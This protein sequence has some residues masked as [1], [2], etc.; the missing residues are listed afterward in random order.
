MPQG[1]KSSANKWAREIATI[2]NHTAQLHKILVYQDD[3]VNTTKAFHQH[4]TTQ[5]AVYD[6]LGPH[7]MV[8][9][10]SKTTLNYPSQKILGHVMSAAGR[11]ADPGLVRTIRDLAI[12]RTLHDIQ[13]L[14]GL[15]KVAI[16]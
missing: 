5:Q 6:V 7:L 13:S 15:A 1:V 10:P 3:I 16:D 14:L 9:K 11:S 8:F 12:P 2:F 4:Y